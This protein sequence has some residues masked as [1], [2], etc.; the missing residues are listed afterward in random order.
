M[1]ACA[2]R[3][4]SILRVPVTRPNKSY[5]GPTLVRVRSEATLCFMWSKM[6]VAD[7]SDAKE[8][9]KL[10][11]MRFEDFMEAIVRMATMKC[12]P[13][14]EEVEQAGFDDGGQLLLALRSNPSEDKAFRSVRPAVWNM[15]LRQPIWRCAHHLLCFFARIIELRVH[16]VN[17]YSHN[18]KLSQREVTNFKKNQKIGVDERGQAESPAPLVRRTTVS[19][20]TV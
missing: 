9:R 13:T 10:A 17:V 2:F 19:K 16:G 12:V 20:V 3:L 4:P 18:L 5:I 11:N 6:R 8:R 1:S 7:E 15:P 14:D